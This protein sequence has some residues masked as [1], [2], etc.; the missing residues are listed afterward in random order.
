MSSRLARRAT[1]Q[2]K[3]YAACMHALSHFFTPTLSLVHVFFFLAQ[4]L[5]ALMAI[6]REKKLAKRVKKDNLTNDGE[7]DAD[8]AEDEEEEE[9]IYNVDAMHDKLEDFAWIEQQPW[10][11]TLAITTDT[12]TQVENVDDDLERELAFYNQALAAAKSAIS[13]FEEAGVPWRRPV[14]Y[15]AEMVKSDDH[16]TKVKE[17]L[18]YEQQVI[19]TAEQRRRDRETKKFGKQVAAEKKKERDHEKK[20]AI[21]SVSALRKQREKSGFAGDV[22]M[23]KELARLDGGGGGGAGR[24]QQK[25]KGVLGERFSAHQK[26]SKRANRD[27]KYGFGGPKRLQKQNDAY[28]A[29]GG[30]YRP[31]SKTKGG[32]VGGK[33]GGKGKQQRPGKSRRA[34]MKTK[35]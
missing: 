7:E 25:K 2:M 10:A 33:G 26:S 29:A 22:D 35:R 21:T 30:D 11:E 12:P 19:E 6:E 9:A 8:E 13:K 3:R 27:S 23:D 15:Y 16:M 20:K 31:P 32:G 4:E 14:D 1:H 24:Q 17:Q 5:A 28:S 34:S 18:L